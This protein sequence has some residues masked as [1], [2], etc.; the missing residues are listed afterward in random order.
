[1]K[2]VIRYV[3]LVDELVSIRE[4]GCLWCRRGSEHPSYSRCRNNLSRK[5]AGDMSMHRRVNVERPTV[6]A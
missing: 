2:E 4:G 3:D 1:M 6:A 5:T